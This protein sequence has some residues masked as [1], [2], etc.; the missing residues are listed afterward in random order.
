MEA[1]VSAPVCPLRTGPGPDSALAD[2]ALLGMAVEVVDAGVG[3]WRVRTSYRYEGWAPKSCLV[4]GP[5]AR[6]W[7]GLEKRAV[8]GKCFADIL[9]G[10]DFRAPALESAPMGALLAVTGPD[11][12]GWTAVELPDGRRGHTRTSWL[13]TWAQ[14]PPEMERGALRQRIIDVALA[15]TAA[16]YRWGG[17]TPRG[18]DCSGLVSM[19]Y[20][21]SGIVIYRDARLQEGFDLVE[22]PTA[23]IEPADVLFFPGHVAL[24]LG[25]GRYL[26]ATGR[27]GS[28]G[29]VQN[30][31]EPTAAGYRA[32]LARS[33][34]AVGSYK[35]FHR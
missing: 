32:D 31:L 14:R 17:K 13:G 12:G 30:T 5:R 24:Y 3:H 10:P 15:Y 8:L 21:L 1:V 7:R 33:I 35:G 20:L 18:I 2:E 28:D 16:P 26:H 19:A 27:A 34:T 29:V 4:T 23:D 25:G 22:I 11:A 9:A 6:A